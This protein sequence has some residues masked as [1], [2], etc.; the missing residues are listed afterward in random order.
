MND[1]AAGLES[2]AIVMPAYNEQ[3]CIEQVVRSW[4]GVLE[5][6]PGTLIVVNDGSR[7]KTGEIL[8]RLA[9]SHA[10]LRVV[11]QKNA[12]HGA[13]VMR[14]YR[15]AITLGASYVFQTDSDDQFDREDFWKL[16]DLRE[17][18]PFVL[19]N[20]SQRHDPLVRIIISRLNAVL[21]L[22]FFGT[23][24]RDANC[25]FRLFRGSLLKAMMDILPP[26]V[27]AP[28]IFLAV[29]ARRGGIPLLEL[30]VTH[31]ER[32]TGTVSILRL[33][34]LKVCLRCV[35]ELF[36]FRRTLSAK[37]RELEGLP[38][39]SG[40]TKDGEREIA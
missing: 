10:S 37:A 13:A 25:P 26:T 31:R 1:N 11:H 35:E 29:I 7:D 17:T 16:W 32:K 40:T 20:R 19:G 14:G 36:A 39:A 33:K 18:S 2:L 3:G 15:E 5:R 30:P 24:V 23:V 22:L 28:N 27:F 21:L 12:G 4:L 34:L 38:A 9:S 8:D 6:V